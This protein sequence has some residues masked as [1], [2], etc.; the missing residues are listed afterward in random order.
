MPFYEISL[1]AQC[2]RSALF[3]IMMDYL[4]KMINFGCVDET[5][6]CIFKDHF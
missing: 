3:Y 5:Q 2:P 1:K 4:K 6:M